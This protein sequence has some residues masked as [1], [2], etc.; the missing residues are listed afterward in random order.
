M[1]SRLFGL[2]VLLVLILPRE[3]LYVCTS[4]SPEEIGVVV[5]EF[6]SRIIFRSH[7]SCVV[8][9]VAG[10]FLGA[11]QACRNTNITLLLKSGIPVWSAISFRVYQFFIKVLRTHL[12]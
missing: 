11:R 10:M 2:L 5:T 12:T 3:N 4:S 9:V 6:Q 8:M 7:T 1:N